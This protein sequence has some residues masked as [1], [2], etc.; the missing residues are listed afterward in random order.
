M[1]LND[2]KRIA[3]MV[4][5]H[6]KALKHAVRLEHRLRGLLAHVAP[7]DTE[8]RMTTLTALAQARAD[9]LAQLGFGVTVRDVNDALALSDAD[10]PL[11]HDDALPEGNE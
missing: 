3:R 7:E 5:E 9:A 4:Y 11:P 1:T 2:A 10:E 8:L 6:D